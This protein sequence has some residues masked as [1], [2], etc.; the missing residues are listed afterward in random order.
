MLMQIFLFALGGLLCGVS[1]N[2]T[3]LIVGRS[4]SMHVIGA[5][6]SMLIYL[7]QLYKVLVQVA[8]LH[9]VK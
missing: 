9:S 2:M 8:L 6:G 1:Q 4:K 7:V 3:I 5:R